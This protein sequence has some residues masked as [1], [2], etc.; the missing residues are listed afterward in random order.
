M[1]WPLTTDTPVTIKF[2][3]LGQVEADNSVSHSQ[4]GVKMCVSFQLTAEA[5]QIIQLLTSDP[6]GKKVLTEDYFQNFEP[7]LYTYKESSKV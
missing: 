6:E 5:V 2:Y 3:K 4:G 1:T 7:K